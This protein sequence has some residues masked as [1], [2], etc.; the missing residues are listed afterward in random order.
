MVGNCKSNGTKFQENIGEYYQNL[1]LKQSIICNE[2][3]SGRSDNEILML[4]LAK[5][6]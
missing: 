1:L 4:D 6:I 5:F 3:L 2:G